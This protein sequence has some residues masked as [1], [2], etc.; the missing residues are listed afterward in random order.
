MRKHTVDTSP[1]NATSVNM[2]QLKQIIFG[3]TSW[4]TSEKGAT[5]A[6]SVLIP[7]IIKAIYGSTWSDII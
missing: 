5:N 7:L 4:G 1:T 3:S 2:P 6:I